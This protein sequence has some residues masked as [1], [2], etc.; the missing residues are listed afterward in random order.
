MNLSRDS[1]PT[2]SVFTCVYNMADKIHRVFD[3]MLAQTYPNI[4][5]I[6][7]DDGSTDDLAPL[8]RAYMEKA[9]YPVIFLQKE[10]GGKHTAT[11]LAWDTATGEYIIQLDADDAY[12][13]HSIEYL[14]GKWNEIPEEVREQYWCVQGRCRDQIEGK[15]V[16]PLYPEKINSL[17]HE[18]A[19]KLAAQTPGEKIGMMKRAALEGYRY[20][21][22]RGVKFVQEAVLWKPLNLRYRTY[23][24][25]E[26]V[27]IYYIGEGGTLSTPSRTP[28]ALSNRC[29]DAAWRIWHAKDYGFSIP[30]EALR[31]S[32]TYHLAT[33]DYRRYN[34]Y[35]RGFALP[36]Q[37][38]LILLYLPCAV[39]AALLKLKYRN[40]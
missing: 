2:V 30:R 1:H 20:P 4:E 38:G 25:N 9:P 37:L 10:N 24:T 7:V 13:P 27:R 21:Q 18:E 11:N 36:V 33:R 23:Y 14:V 15:M 31:Y 34:P 29:W 6:I 22:P 16:G 39:G 40:Q 8:V 32:L 28:Q 19:R 35:L 3:S 5:H 17:S 12:L 26:I